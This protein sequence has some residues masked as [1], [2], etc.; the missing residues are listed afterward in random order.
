MSEVKMVGFHH[1][2]LCDSYEKQANEQGFTFGENAEFFQK[3]GFGLVAAY[4]HG[5]ITD[6]EYDKILKR[7]QKELV[8]N[9]K[10]LETK[11]ALIVEPDP[12]A[13]RWKEL[14]SDRGPLWECPDCGYRVNPEDGGIYHYCSACGK[15]LEE[16]DG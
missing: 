15:K 8:K 13:D 2:A 5:F 9:L 1:G 14:H 3:V 16:D 11:D 4:I 6:S 12:Q 7:F 10:P